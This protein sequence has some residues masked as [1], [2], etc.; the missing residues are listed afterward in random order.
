VVI[1]VVHAAYESTHRAIALRETVSLE[2]ALAPVID[3]ITIVE[4]APPPVDMRSTAA[5]SGAALE[6]K[7]GQSL[8]ATLADVPGVTELRL[9]SGAAKPI[10]R[11]H[12]G[13]RLPLLVD[14]VRHRSQDWGLDHAPEIDPAI[15]DRITVVRGASGV[16]YGPD[17][18]GG[19]VLVDP[20]EL[21]SQRGSSGEAHLVGY[22]NGLGGSLMGRAQA[23]PG[24]S[25]LTFQLE[26]SLKRLRSPGTPDYPLDNTGEQEWTAGTAIAYRAAGA[27]YQLSFRHF[28]TELGV[29]T[30][31]RVDSAEDF[32]AQ[33]RRQRPIAAELYAHEFA[34]ER[35][36]QAVRHELALA[37]ARWSGGA[38]GRIT[39]TYALQ[40]DDRREYDIV[41]QATTGPQFVF[42]LWTHD[43]D[44]ALEHSP[45]HLSDHHHL[46]G[47]VGLAGMAQ[48]HS[49]QGLPL[50]PDHQAGAGAVYASERLLGH[51][52]E[53]EAGV[54]YDFLARTAAITRGDF[55]RL[56]R[57]GQLT[58]D[59]CGPFS[60]STDPVTCASAYHTLS[61]SLG[62]NLQISKG[63]SAKLDLSLASRPPNPD[64]QYINGTAPSFPVFGVGRPDIGAETSYSASA[65]VVYAG[66]RLRGELSA[67]GNLI[68]DYIY[69][70][71]SIGPDGQPS[72]DVLIRGAFPRFVT[73][74]VDAVFWGADGNVV[75]SPVRWLELQ[76]QASAVRAR[77]LT[78]DAYLVF[79]PPDRLRASVAVTSRSLL[80]LDSV[81][82]SVAGT[83][84]ARQSRFELAADL[85]P[86][87]VAY[88]LAEASVEART[89]VAGQTATVALQGTNLLGRRYR[90]YTS[91]LRYFAEQ[92]G[93]QLMLRISMSYSTTTTKQ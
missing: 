47:S 78:N 25:A 68:S 8:S 55:L 24:D 19:V 1:D 27:T 50:V 81:M 89:R 32:F 41:R 29:C 59:A 76:A 6:R 9:G 65:T 92:P 93:R 7:R 40:Y 72:F 36:F 35:P 49:Y 42:R 16:R 18:I 13:R 22:A 63:W 52:Y 54:R 44:L 38:L 17:A 48:V 77:N 30:C 28:E 21:L 60:D 73:R 11:G 20:P 66:E 70:A 31:F 85:A 84:A 10:V 74:A 82:G 12:F 45:I 53:I 86:P 46:A 57:S 23:V 87:P 56:V 88:F 34:I 80:G 43:L 64:E 2:I 71:P 4:K 62:G 51:H 58:G 69:F 91:L 37:R 3:S 26:G 33:A 15:A 67:F 39:A 5:I 83:Y 75:A 14:G 61:A 79:V 90:E